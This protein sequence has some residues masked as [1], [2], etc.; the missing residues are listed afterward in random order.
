M[1]TGVL[2]MLGAESLLLGSR[3][4]AG[5]ALFFLVITTIYLV[6]VEE[7]EL[8][9]RFGEDCRRYR[10]NVPRWIPRVAPWEPG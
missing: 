10:A 1:I 7:P 6:R 3:P 9:R 2:L 4:V 8:A 5:W